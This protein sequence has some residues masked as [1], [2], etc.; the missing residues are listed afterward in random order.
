MNIANVVTLD[1]KIYRL[2]WSAVP[3]KK[4]MII[5]VGTGKCDNMK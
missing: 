3:P 2:S 5:L 1:L 4:F